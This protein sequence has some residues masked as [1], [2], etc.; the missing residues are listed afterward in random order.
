MTTGHSTRDST[1]RSAALSQVDGDATDTELVPD[2]A[3]KLEPATSRHRAG[4]RRTAESGNESVLSVAI[5]PPLREVHCS[6]LA[7]EKRGLDTHPRQLIHHT[8][9]SVSTRYTEIHAP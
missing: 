5:E 8:S 2:R 4:S 9:G 1:L 6:L 3:W 7:R